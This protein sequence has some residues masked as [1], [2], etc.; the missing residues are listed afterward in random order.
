[1]ATNT[2]ITAGRHENTSTNT[3]TDFARAGRPR[4]KSVR[5]PC[6]NSALHAERTE[7]R[8]PS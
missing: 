2:A 6:T 8:S 1:M 5:T 7:S 3:G 4:P